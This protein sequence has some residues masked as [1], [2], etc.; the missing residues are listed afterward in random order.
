MNATEEKTGVMKL[1]VKA[2]KRGIVKFK[3]LWLKK[4]SPLIAVSCC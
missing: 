1:V 3:L 2:V 4:I